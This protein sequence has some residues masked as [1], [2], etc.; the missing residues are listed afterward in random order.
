MQLIEARNMAKL[1][2]VGTIKAKAD[3]ISLV[4]VELDRL[5]DI[6]RS[7]EGCL[8]YDLHQDNNDPAHFMCYESRESR[9]LVRRIWVHSTCRTR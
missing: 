8:Q 6:T 3:K 2:V 7:E 5:I 1:T 9:E 4:K